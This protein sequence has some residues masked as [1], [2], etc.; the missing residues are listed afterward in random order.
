MTTVALASI[1]GVQAM[2]TDSRETWG[3]LVTSDEM[4]K[5]FCEGMVGPVVACAGLTRG[6]NLL[7]KIVWAGDVWDF[8]ARMKELL[9]G[10]DF[11]SNEAEGPPSYQA[12]WGFLTSDGVWKVARDL[13]VC[14]VPPEFPAAFGSGAEIAI[15]AMD[16]LLM[17]NPAATAREVVEHGVRVAIRRDTDS[18][19]KVQLVVRGKEERL[20]P[21]RID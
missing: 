6:F 5:I 19:G 11:T 16:S 12:S 13:A 10:A 3:G 8:Q 7:R 15:G 17:H 14:P 2:A 21:Q 9:D 4:T 1:G 18:G 20:G